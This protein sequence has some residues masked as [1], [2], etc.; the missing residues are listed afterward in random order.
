MAK[1]LPWLK[2][3]VFAGA[4]AP[5]AML[6]LR[7]AF[8]RLGAN[9]IAEALNRLGLTTLVFLVA[10]LACTPLKLMAGWTWPARVRRMLGLFAFF[11]GTL[12]FATYLCL[13][14]AFDFRAIGEDIVKRKFILVGFLAL[15]LMAPLAVTSTDAMVRRLGFPRWKCLAYFA[16]VLGAIHFVWRVK[17]DV[18]EPAIYALVVS[19]LL[20]MRAWEAARRAWKRGR[21]TQ[22]TGS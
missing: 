7:A 6:G 11:Y 5:V 15:L 1:P 13:D 12:H 8:G 21:T 9:P 17:R 16:G 22:E 20:G 14:Q 19:L 4:L 3:A 18:T 10:A 2:P